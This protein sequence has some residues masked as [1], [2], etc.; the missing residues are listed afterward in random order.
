MTTDRRFIYMTKRLRV[1]V[2]SADD[3]CTDGR[4]AVYRNKSGQNY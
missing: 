1:I 3:G 2:Q 4:T